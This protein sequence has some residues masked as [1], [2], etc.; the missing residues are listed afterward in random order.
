MF[1]TIKKK[2][3]KFSIMQGHMFKGFCLYYME[4]Q[5]AFMGALERK[6][7][8]DIPMIMCVNQSDRMH[9]IMI[10]SASQPYQNCKNIMG[11]NHSHQK[12]IL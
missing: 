10:M 5:F 9:K 4:N 8:N 3:R 1:Q 6:L 2:I 11:H 7:L 12:S